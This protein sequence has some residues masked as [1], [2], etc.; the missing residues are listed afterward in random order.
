VPGRWQIRNAWPTKVS[1]PQ[2]QSDSNAYAVEELS[3]TFEFLERE[4]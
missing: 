1:G 3:I 4:S 2:F